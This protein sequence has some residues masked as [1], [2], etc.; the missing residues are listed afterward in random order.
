MSETTLVGAVTMALARAM[1]EDDAVVVLGE[2]VGVNGGVFRATQGLLER[3]GRERVLDTPLAELA[4]GGVAVGMA[5]AGLRPVAEIQF[6]GFIYP[7]IDQIVSHASRLRNRTRGRLTC[8]MVLRAPCGGGIHA[9]EHHCESNEAMFAHMP[10]LRV[11]IPS[12]PQRA[13]GLL[14][15]AIRD[16]DPV[17][18][19]E[20]ARIYRAIRQ[21]VAD[22]GEGLPLDTCFVLREGRDLTLITWGAMV[23]E[24]LAAA[25]VARGRGGLGR[26]D[27][28]RDPEAAR[29][30]DDPR[31]GRED[32]ALR[33][34]ARGRA[35]RR[36]RR[37]DRRAHRR[38]GPPVAAGAARARHRLRHGHALAQARASLHAE[39]G[40]HPGGRPPRARVRLTMP[41]PDEPKGR[42]ARRALAFA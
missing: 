31:L 14:L 11:V 26:G 18:F 21:E 19:L 29:L 28:R 36:L 22:D 37:R 7:A 1:E 4:I 34:R 42:A 23:K 13:Y 27:R 17:V 3:F 35:H 24:T 2:D 39:R 40:A 32:R 15:A 10:G 16:P 12:S 9:P 8:P 20:P 30:R 38:E 6:S 41:R 25:E 5:A 33:D